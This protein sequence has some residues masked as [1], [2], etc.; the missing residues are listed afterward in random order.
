MNIASKTATSIEE[1]SLMTTRPQSSTAIMVM[2]IQINIAQG[3]RLF[4]IQ[5]A[6]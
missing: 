6:T 2:E 1:K 5:E 3:I 4:N